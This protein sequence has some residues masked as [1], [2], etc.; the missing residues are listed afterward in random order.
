MDSPSFVLSALSVLTKHEDPDGPMKR[1]IFCIRQLT[2]SG[3]A[4]VY[5]HLAASYLASSLAIF[6]YGVT[7]RCFRR[8]PEVVLARA[9]EI[10][11]DLQTDESRLRDARAVSANPGETIVPPA[12][13]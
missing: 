2:R 1:E 8:R 10:F 6:D 12:D 5:P 7:S 4:P 9:C 11:G 13:Q 3:S